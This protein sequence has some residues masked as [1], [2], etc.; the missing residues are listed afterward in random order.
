MIV[1]SDQYQRVEMKI[2]LDYL[3]MV[4][5]NPDLGN[6]EEKTEVKYEGEPIEMGFN[7][8]YFIDTL[9]SMISDMIH[10]N[11]KDQT[12]PCLITGD[13]DEG[14]LGLIMPMRV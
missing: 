11:I 14:F 4:S 13:Q 7:P 1:R 3:E 9:Q 8:R 6:V 5:V 2:G 12:S 10:L